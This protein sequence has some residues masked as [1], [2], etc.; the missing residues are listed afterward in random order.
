MSAAPVDE[1]FVLPIVT[2]LGG[3]PTVTDEGDIVYVFEELQLSAESTLEAAGLQPDATSADIKAYLTNIGV[4]TR[5]AVEKSDL[6]HLLDKSLTTTNS[7]RSRQPDPTEPLQELE[8]PFNRNGVGW[9]ALAGTLGLINLGGA[10][11]LGALLPQLAAQGI[12]LPSYF[13][14][15]QAG[16]PLLLAYAVLY[17]AIPLIRYL[18]NKA[19]N[20]K[21]RQRNAARQ[22]WSTVLRSMGGK[23]RRK[24]RA[25]RNFRTD[26]RRLGTS[27]AV[28]DTRQD[29][30]QVEARREEDALR[31]FDELLKDQNNSF[32]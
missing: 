12:R 18:S 32:Q 17:N 27:D 24:I 11:Y 9:N 19:K 13:G 6:L 1:S 8:L 3:V 10:L 25:A 28:Y 20:Q 14:L 4:S 2:Q 5:G 30:R 22:R 26:M 15:V 23:V 7:R 31:A 29:V 21:I 16:Y